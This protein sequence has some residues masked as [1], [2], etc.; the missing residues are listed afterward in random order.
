MCIS[1]IGK[2]MNRHIEAG[3]QYVFCD[4]MMVIKGNLSCST[5]VNTLASGIKNLG[6]NPGSVPPTSC[7]TWYELNLI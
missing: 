3:T 1:A 5:A 7:I 6:S 2:R 4:L